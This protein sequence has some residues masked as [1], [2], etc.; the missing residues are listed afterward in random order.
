MTIKDNIIYVGKVISDKISLLNQELVMDQR[1]IYLIDSITDSYGNNYG[2]VLYTR[3]GYT[4][5]KILFSFLTEN[6]LF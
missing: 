4:G 3:T 5:E 6:T 1:N 2:N